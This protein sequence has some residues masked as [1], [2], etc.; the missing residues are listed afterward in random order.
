[1]GIFEER[2]IYPLVNS[3]FKQRINEVH[4]S[5]K[6]DFKFSN[7]ETDFLDTVKYKTLTGK[8]ET[9]LYAKDTDRQAYLHADQNILRP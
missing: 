4:P 1:M 2:F 3:K 5:I 7:K 9:K 6:F 8:F